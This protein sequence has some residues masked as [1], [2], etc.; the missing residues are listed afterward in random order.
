[1]PIEFTCSSCHAVLETIEQTIGKLAI[2]PACESRQLV[3]APDADDL[4]GGLRHCSIDATDLLATAWRIYTTR[5]GRCI[6]PVV[7]VYLAVFI[8]FALTMGASLSYFLAFDL[9][10]V[11]R[12]LARDEL[13]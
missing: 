12:Q 1:M 4:G 5:P 2:C 8:C 10:E 13:A 7:I 11:K 6:L 3:A 9:A